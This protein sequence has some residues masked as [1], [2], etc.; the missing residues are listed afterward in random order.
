ALPGE[1]LLV[2]RIDIDRPMTAP[3]R[4]ALQLVQADGRSDLD[5]PPGTLVNQGDDG[6]PF[7]GSAMQT[8]VGDTGPV[9]SSF[10]D[11][12]SGVKLSNITVDPVPREVSLDITI[13]AVPASPPAPGAGASVQDLATPNLPPQSSALVEGLKRTLGQQAVSPSELRP[14]VAAVS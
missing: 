7:P 8:S 5:Q 9:S 2:W 1:G 6:D 4:P 12:R 14:F 13:S 3:A 11:H 10:H